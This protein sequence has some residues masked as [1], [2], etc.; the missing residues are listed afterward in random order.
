MRVKLL[1]SY[2]S[3][4]PVVSTRIGAEGLAS[5]DGE[6]CRLADDPREFARAILDLFANP[7]EAE[8]MAR[9][10]RAEVER[11]WDMPVLTQALVKEYSRIVASKRRTS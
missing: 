11:N 9:R 10:A 4:I 3:G 5:K 1:E 7:G 6:I 2:A 8:A